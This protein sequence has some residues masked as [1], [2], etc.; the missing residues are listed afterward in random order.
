MNLNERVFKAALHRS[1]SLV[2]LG[3][4]CSLDLLTLPFHSTKATIHAS[5]QLSWGKRERESWNENKIIY[6][7]F[8]ERK[9][10]KQI[11]SGVGKEPRAVLQSEI[12]LESLKKSSTVSSFDRCWARCQ[13]SGDFQLKSIETK[14]RRNWDISVS[15]MITGTL[16]S[17]ANWISSR[18]KVCNEGEL[19]SFSLKR[20]AGG[21]EF[22]RKHPLERILQDVMQISY[23]TNSHSNRSKSSTWA[24]AWD[25]EIR[26]SSRT[27]A[28][29]K[30][31]TWIMVSWVYD[32]NKKMLLWTFDFCAGR[33]DDWS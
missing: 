25:I 12:H 28:K 4:V 31:Q 15:W 32:G 13:L 11:S 19:R 29:E 30:F 1:S 9:K 24:W 33:E 8:T 5:F 22:A 23:V 17:S 27:L 16:M 6:L 26:R 10:E 3:V 20:V 18:P 14:K 7:H 21:R 2:L